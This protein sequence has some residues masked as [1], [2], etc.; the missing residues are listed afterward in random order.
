MQTIA[1]ELSD[2]KCVLLAANVGTDM[3]GR[4]ADCMM[5][6]NGGTTASYLA[7]SPRIPLTACRLPGTTWYRFRC[8]VEP[9]LG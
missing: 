7:R 5:E 1:L 2:E 9:L 6:M 4:P 8:T 3:I